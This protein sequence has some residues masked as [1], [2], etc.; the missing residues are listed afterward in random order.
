MKCIERFENVDRQSGFLKGLAARGLDGCFSRLYSP[1][2]R[3]PVTG[4]V[5]LPGTTANKQHGSVASND[6]RHCD[7]ELGTHEWEAYT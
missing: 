4:S 2:Y 3:F 1:G 7:Y 5:V 6:E